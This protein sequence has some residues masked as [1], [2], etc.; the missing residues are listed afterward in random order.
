MSYSVSFYF[1]EAELSME[2]GT[3]CSIPLFP[4]MTA[5][6]VDPVVGAIAQTLDPRL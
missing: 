4:D 5:N 3:R 6:D 1:S 2:L